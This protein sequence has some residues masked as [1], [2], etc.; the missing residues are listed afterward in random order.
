MGMGDFLGNLGS[1]LPMTESAVERPLR[2][3]IELLTE[4]K[5]L[6]G[7]RIGSPPAGGSS[8][9]G[10]HS[11][12]GGRGGGGSSGGA[13]APPPPADIDLQ[14]LKLPQDV[15]DVVQPVI[16]EFDMF[17]RVTE[18]AHRLLKKASM[19]IAVNGTFSVYLLH[20][21]SK[22][23]EDAKWSKDVLSLGFF[24]RKGDNVRIISKECSDPDPA[25]DFAWGT[26]N[27]QGI[28]TEY[29][30][31]RRIARLDRVPTDERPDLLRVALRLPESVKQRTGP[32]GPLRLI[33]DTT[34]F[35]A[36]IDLIAAAGTTS[37][38][39]VDAFV[40]NRLIGVLP[41]EMRAER[42]EWGQNFKAA[43]RE[44]LQWAGAKGAHPLRPGYTCLGA[45]LVVFLDGQGIG[46]R[47]AIVEALERYQLVTNANELAA[48]RAQY[49]P[50]EGD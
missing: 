38:A 19:H 3:W 42:I 39:G 22:V 27:E 18:K 7:P 21:S 28:G 16:N 5:L 32:T 20:F 26:W 29:V 35:N 48:I 10:G 44:L 11:G 46:G 36:L 17:V 31:W 8:G 37:G 47:K 2:A 23:L 41:D 12:G 50:P 43:A 49:I 9:S 30:E 13:G 15:L 25:Y 14:D 33:D 45:V 4:T 34:R 1:G 24:F 40:N 6:K